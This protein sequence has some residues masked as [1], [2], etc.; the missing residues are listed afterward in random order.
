[1]LQEHNLDIRHIKQKIISSKM[2][3]LGLSCHCTA[4]V[5]FVLLLFIDLICFYIIVW[6][7]IVYSGKESFTSKIFLFFEEG[8]C[9]R[10]EWCLF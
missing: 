8:K 3:S 2:H 5:E 4:H 9:N 1:M 10:Y 6:N 7:I